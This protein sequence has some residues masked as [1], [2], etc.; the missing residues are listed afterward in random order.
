MDVAIGGRYR[1]LSSL[2]RGGMGEVFLAEDLVLG[3]Q[4]AVKK[5][6]ADPAEQ[7]G[8]A[9][10]RLVREA[11]SAALIHHPHVVTVHDFVT[12]DEHA[13]IIM[14][15]VDAPN[16][17]QIIKATGGMSPERARHAG[18]QV[19]AGLA[20]AH[21]LGI[22]HRD[23]KPSNILLDAHGTAKLTDFGVARSTGDTGLTQT[24][25]MIGSVAYM[26]PEVA[27]G[28]QA[29]SASDVYS[30]GATLFAA[31]EG[32]PPFAR[33]G[34]ASTSVSLLV[35]LVTETA[36]VSAR[37]GALGDLIA[38]MLSTDPQARPSA[39]EVAS[40]LSA[41]VS[42]SQQAVEPGP[43][44]A[45]PAGVSAPA[46]AGPLTLTDDRTV[47]RSS[48]IASEPLPVTSAAP[49]APEPLAKGPAMALP[50]K[51]DNEATRLRGDSEPAPTSLDAP[52][53]S[54]P[55][56]Y[57]VGPL[58]P[59]Q[60]A[61]VK[62]GRRTRI[63]AAALT[64]T[65]LGGVALAIMG[66][67]A[68]PAMGSLAMDSPVPVS[69]GLPTPQASATA[70]PKFRYQDYYGSLDQECS[71]KITSMDASVDGTTL[72]LHLSL[73][74]TAKEV[75]SFVAELS[76]DADADAEYQIYVDSSEAGLSTPEE[77]SWDSRGSL[78]GYVDGRDVVVSVPLSKLKPKQPISLEVYHW[79]GGEESS[80]SCDTALI[81]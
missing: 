27:R 22:V 14:E 36:P 13:Y 54:S 30:L 47:L 10:Q 40:R 20:A 45:P 12:E 62:R 49:T 60:A 63:L 59:N 18:A 41:P 50:P 19:A 4:V 68:D 1:V 61:V 65:T 25:H 80:G 23:V 8:V 2:G 34:E 26:S 42:P 66:Q 24:G 15:Y 5:L 43:Q 17:A 48:R 79:S 7:D 53:T 57:A 71:G 28:A 52:P 33:P 69:L 55:A 11:R 46:P 9:A 78:F 77:D 73:S 75:D 38:R 32:R 21:H 67:S 64:L 3:R 39:D 44:P 51:D 74:S 58:T 16:L 56:S 37:A 70:T 35:R 29:D 31:V 6:L 76:L 81:E 72:D